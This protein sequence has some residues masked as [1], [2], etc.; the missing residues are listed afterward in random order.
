[1]EYPED[2]NEVEG[3]FS[4]AAE[5]MR[6]AKAEGR[7]RV[8]P[9]GWDA[10]Q[11]EKLRCADVVLVMADEAEACLL[12]NALQ[13]R[14]YRARWLQDG[15]TALKMLGG[16]RPSLSARVIMIEMELPGMDG[17][18]LLKHL[19][20]SGSL[21][22]SRVIMLTSPAVGDDAQTA[23]QLGAFDQVVK[24]FNPPVVVQRIR[25]ALES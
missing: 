3:L 12:L 17:L 16:Q 4:A 5:A 21:K 9:A 8:L 7:D 20:W 25:R 1:A 24:P 10:G 2:A 14:G 15:K 19:A 6:L 11:R 22:E 18:S 13:T 23:L